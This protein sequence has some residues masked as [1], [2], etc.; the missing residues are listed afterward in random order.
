ME[1]ASFRYLFL[2][3]AIVMPF[4]AALIPSHGDRLSSYNFSYIIVKAF[5][6]YVVGVGYILL[7]LSAINIAKGWRPIGGIVG[8][9]FWPTWTGIF[10]YLKVFFLSQ[11]S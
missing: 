5:F 11:D 8:V 1:D 9:F 7:T 4:L 2:G 10:S 3:L 6:Y